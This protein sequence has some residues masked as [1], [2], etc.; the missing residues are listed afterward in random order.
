MNSTC[1]GLPNII[2]TKYTPI[3]IIWF[4]CLVLSTCY[5]SYTIIKSFLYFLSFPV[6]INMNFVHEYNTKFP[7]VTICNL[8]A[9]NT[10]TAHEFINNYLN[11]LNL[12]IERF[13]IINESISS[14]K[15]F[16]EMNQNLIK[17][18]IMSNLTIKN[19]EKK[20]LG[21]DLDEM[22]ISCFYNG[23][24]CKISD[25]KWIFTYDYG[26]CFV[27]NS[28]NKL[29]SMKPGPKN[30]LKMEFFIGEPD[31]ELDYTESVGLHVF[32]HN[33]SISLLFDQEGIDIASGKK[34]SIGVRRIFHNKLEKPYS[35]CVRNTH[36][37]NAY[38]SDLYRASI[39]ENSSYRQIYCFELCYQK[40]LNLKCKCSDTSIEVLSH[41]LKPCTSV[42]E[43]NC[44]NNFN[45]EFYKNDVEA[46][47]KSECPLECDKVSYMT[48]IFTSDFPSPYYA[49]LLQKQPWFQ[50]K[51]E[52]NMSW[53]E[54]KHTLASLNIFYEDMSYILISEVAEISITTFLAN[55]GGELGLFLGISLLSLVEMVELLILIL[56]EI[57]NYR[58][59]RS[60]VF[61]FNF[62][63]ST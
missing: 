38:N 47:C 54:I 25:F 31:I 10:R 39:N 43:L 40:Q 18:V 28:E 14:P 29:R 45:V 21:F 60:Q 7:A 27:F 12:T 6:L 3:R 41:S 53:N 1:H 22:L 57:K 55:C 20:K 11:K 33:Q 30:G 52:R 19:K 24:K 49:K 4:F 50:S 26:N 32:V 63:H 56:I 23:E 48:N 37:I 62:K 34:T 42:E 16:V 35:D 17:S 46:Q 44:S 61:D 13:P 59:S 15:E 8:N 9:I 51:L 36:S 2:R 58:R 5:C